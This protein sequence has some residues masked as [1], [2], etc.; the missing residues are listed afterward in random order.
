MTAADKKII[1]EKGSD[2]RLILKIKEDDGLLNRNLSGYIGNGVPVTKPAEYLDEAWGWVLQ[3]FHKNGKRHDCKYLKGEVGTVGIG[4]KVYDTNEMVAYKNITA[5]PVDV[6]IDTDYDNVAVWKRD[7]NAITAATY[8]KTSTNG[9]QEVAAEETVVDS[10]SGVIFKNTSGSN[11]TIADIS[12]TPANWT[13]VQPSL[14]V[15]VKRFDEE[16]K[17]SDLFNGECVIN[18]ESSDI[19]KIRTGNTSDPFD[20]VFNYYYVITLYEKFTDA[21]RG[22][23]SNTSS[24]EMRILRGN[25]AVRM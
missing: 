18:I 9:V 12:A 11:K 25:L 17:G 23:T 4:E 19:M 24:R 7:G 6:V 13:A 22:I 16:Y 15:I 20:T 3:I 2:Y 21:L 1:L 14:G 8:V 10:S 5:A